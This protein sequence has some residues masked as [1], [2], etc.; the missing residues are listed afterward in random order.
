MLD[1]IADTWQSKRDC[2]SSN[3]TKYK[4]G[5]P[6]FGHLAILATVI[7]DTSEKNDAIRSLLDASQKWQLYVAPYLD[8]Y[9][10]QM[11]SVSTI[12]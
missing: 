12:Q 11:I 9:N 2:Q 4:V 1:I 3:D 6:Y 8:D 7:V 5:H 10:L